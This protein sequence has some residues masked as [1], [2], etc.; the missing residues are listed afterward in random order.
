M[1]FSIS[2]SS[3]MLAAALFL[4]RHS[5]GRAGRCLGSGGGSSGQLAADLRQQ[6]RLLL[7]HGWSILRWASSAASPIS[8]SADGGSGLVARP[9]A[10]LAAAG[11][12]RPGSVQ[13][14]SMP[15]WKSL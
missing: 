6:Q 8:V 5:F 4:A 2:A 12:R 13:K 7:L 9:L 11:Q 3:L 1:R 15:R 10:C 14:R